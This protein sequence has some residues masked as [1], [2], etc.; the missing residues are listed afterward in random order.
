M[1]Q[2]NKIEGKNYTIYKIITCPIRAEI[3]DVYSKLEK[4]I[5]VLA[6]LAEICVKSLYLYKGHLANS[7]V[8]SCNCY[9]KQL[10]VN[11]F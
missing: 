3:L 11:F 1:K 2:D 9:V 8:L 7:S 10:D 4:C 6:D 5:M